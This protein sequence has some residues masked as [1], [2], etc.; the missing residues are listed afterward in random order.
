MESTNTRE[1]TST[2]ATAAAVSGGVDL[3]SGLQDDL[4]LRILSFLPAASEV[5]RTSVLS[6]RW[7]HLWPSAFA[8]RFSVGRRPETYTEADGDDARRLVAAA[9][10]VLE[11]R[12]GGGPDVEDVELSFLYGSE[13]NTYNTGPNYHAAD[14]TSERLAAW[15]LFA[16]RRVTRRFVLAV[17]SPPK[18]TQEEAG[19]EAAAEE[20][21][22]EEDNEGEEVLAA[23]AEEEEEEEGEEVAVEEETEGAAEVVEEEASVEHDEEEEHAS[24][25]DNEEEEDEDADAHAHAD[26]NANG[27]GNADDDEEED[28]ANNDNNEEEE[29]QD[30]DADGDGDEEEIVFSAELPCSARI[31]EMNL[32]LGGARLTIPP[33]SAAGAFNALTDILLSDA[34]L[35]AADDLRLGDI[36]S[37][38]YSPRLKRLQL[39][40]ITGLTVLRLDSADMDAPNLQT[41]GVARCY[42]IS[43]ARISAPRLRHVVA[44]VNNAKGL[45]L[46]GAASVRR[47]E[48]LMMWSHRFKPEDDSGDEYNDNSSAVWLLR[49]CTSVNQLGVDVTLPWWWWHVMDAHEPLAV[50]ERL[51]DMMMEIPH[52]PNI[53]N[54]KIKVDAYGH[55]MGPSVAKFIAKCTNVE[56]LSIDIDAQNKECSDL[57]C[58]C[59]RPKDWDNQKLSLE[60]LRD[61]EI[62]DFVLLDSQIRLVQLLLTSASALERMTVTLDMSHLEDDDEVEFDI[63][64]YEGHWAPCVWECSELGFVRPTEYEWLRGIKRGEA[65]ED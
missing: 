25:D 48:K 4:L 18:P 10:A 49:N 54:L 52:L 27:D 7:R 26:D 47:I 1:T 38:T 32:T 37:S 50:E 22:E 65:R 51:E 46:D 35:S 45:R 17:P 21:E 36:L 2:S 3:I 30:E 19:E 39:K 15:L 64:C 55:T 53:S 9:S 29:E 8:L 57:S 33:T 20:D 31:K 63:P 23:A 12:A 42:G 16:A 13:D 40:D 11:R 24:D 61:I 56:Y 14:I 6:T 28:D 58:I 44:F 62:C 5:A 34:R 60:N 41:L 43:S 59:Y